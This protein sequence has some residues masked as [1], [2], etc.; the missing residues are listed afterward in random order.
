[1]RRSSVRLRPAAPRACDSTGPVNRFRKILGPARPRTRPL[2]TWAGG[3]R[4]RRAVARARPWTVRERAHAKFLTLR[5]LDRFIDTRGT[6]CR[7]RTGLR[8]GV[9]RM[10]RFPD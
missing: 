9:S 6:A 10:D 8:V 1:M 5:L 7:D 4:A 2:L 3:C